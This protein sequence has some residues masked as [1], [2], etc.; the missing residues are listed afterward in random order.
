M[1][2]T[3]RG[4]SK[5]RAVGAEDRALLRSNPSAAADAGMRAPARRNSLSA[6]RL[7]AANHPGRKAPNLGVWARAPASSP[8]TGVPFGK[9]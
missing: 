5:I 1:L 7:S 2:D 8:P 9:I 4:W 3:S 6:S